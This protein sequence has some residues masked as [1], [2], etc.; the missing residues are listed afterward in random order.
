MPDFYVRRKGGGRRSAKEA[1]ERRIKRKEENERIRQE[2]KCHSEC[3]G[4]IRECLSTLSDRE[5]HSPNPQPNQPK[6]AKREA[7]STIL[8]NPKGRVRQSV[9]RDESTQ[10]ESLSMMQNGTYMKMLYV[11]EDDADAVMDVLE[12]SKRETNNVR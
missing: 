2:T 11:R 10:R 9:D 5:S 12:E 3:V 4:R 6:S 1:N 7:Q 8:M